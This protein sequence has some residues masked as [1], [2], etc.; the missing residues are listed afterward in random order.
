MRLHRAR[1]QPYQ[2]R[3]ATTGEQPWHHANR[4]LCCLSHSLEVS[5]SGLASSPDVAPC[6][7][8]IAPH[9]VRGPPHVP[10]PLTHARL[11]SGLRLTPSHQ[12]GRAQSCQ[13]YR[14]GE[15]RKQHL[16][17]LLHDTPCRSPILRRP[18]ISRATLL[19][20]CTASALDSIYRIASVVKRHQTTFFFSPVAPGLCTVLYVLNVG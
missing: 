18:N 17:S 16:S 1:L 13:K 4:C 6:R 19:A 3:G 14:D 2:C 12:A 7:R 11:T 5:F 9:A 20:T 10:A 8:R 15:N